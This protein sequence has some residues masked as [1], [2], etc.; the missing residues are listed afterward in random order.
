MIPLSSTTS[1]SSSP[2]YGDF[3]F[4]SSF[5]SIF[6]DHSIFNDTIRFLSHDYRCQI[7]TGKKPGQDIAALVKKYIEC[8]EQLK[9]FSLFIIL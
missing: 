5:L 2:D 7:F 9:I 6:K 8:M 4:P 3:V 1:F